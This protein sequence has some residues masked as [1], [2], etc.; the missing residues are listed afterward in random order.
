MEGVPGNHHHHHHHALAGAGS[1]PLHTFSAIHPLNPSVSRAHLMS[2]TTFVEPFLKNSNS[3]LLPPPEFAHPLPKPAPLVPRYN[4]VTSSL[5]GSIKSRLPAKYPDTESQV[6]VNLVQSKDSPSPD[7]R[8]GYGLYPSSRLYTPNVT[9]APHYPPPPPIQTGPYG[10][11]YPPNP[12]T[13]IL[14][15]DGRSTHLLPLQQYPDSNTPPILK[16]PPTSMGSVAHSVKTIYEPPVVPIVAS[17]ASG[18]IRG[19]KRPFKVP[20]GKEGSLKHRILTRPEARGQ[21]KVGRHVNSLLPPPSSAPPTIP[22]DK[23]GTAVSPTD[24][25]Q[26][27]IINSAN[28][29][30]NS[31]ISSSCSSSSSSS[32]SSGDCVHN[33][34]L[35]NFIK[36][37]LIRLA[38]GSTK[39]VEDLQTEDFLSCVQNNSTVRIDPSTVVRIQENAARKGIT[40]VTLSY[41]EQR[42]EVSF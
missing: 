11:L 32:G 35:P 34:V 9:Y 20:S 40:T 38:N 8:S 18:G 4:G 41:G 3:P 7:V 17:E 37:S 26:A 19:E 15:R 16:S 25:A 6:P 28:S 12:F 23:N 21:K 42:N 33:H 30:S 22:C 36:G 10:A 1:H 14:Q 27:A 31:S 39:K 5:N 2:A 24:S 13:P 29:C